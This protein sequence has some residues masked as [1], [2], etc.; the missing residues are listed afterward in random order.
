[1]IKKLE[2]IDEL[3]SEL[4]TLPNPSKAICP[5]RCCYRIGLFERCYNHVYAK[6][7]VYEVIF[8]LLNENQ[9]RVL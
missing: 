6:C 4:V 1:M 9:K 8:E 3:N 5:I 2:A 7:P